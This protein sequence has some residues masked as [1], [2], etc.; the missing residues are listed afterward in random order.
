MA[1]FLESVTLY[2]TLTRTKKHFF[3]QNKEKKKKETEGTL[4]NSFP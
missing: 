2:S 4:L 1:Q 3:V